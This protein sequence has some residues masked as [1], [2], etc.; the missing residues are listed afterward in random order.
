MGCSPEFC[1]TKKEFIE[2]WGKISSNW[3]ICKGMAQIHAL[4]LISPKALSSTC[5]MEQLDMSGGGV[6][7]HL[8]ELMEWGLVY[9]C[10]NNTSRKEYFWAEKDIMT[11]FKQIV[12]NRKKRELEPIIELLNQVEYQEARCPD[13]EEFVK[14]VSDIKSLSVKIDHTLDSVLSTDRQWMLNTF[15]RLVQ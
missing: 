12:E 9:K 5:I 2:R 11:V 7:M 14:V 1:E 3:G 15:F 4:L 10:P 13:S 8:R 6:N